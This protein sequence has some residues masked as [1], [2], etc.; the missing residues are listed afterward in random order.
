[1][2][3]LFFYLLSAIAFL[4]LLSGCN[5]NVDGTDG[6]DVDYHYEAELL[7]LTTD[8]DNPA[9]SLAND[10]IF[11]TIR[12]LYYYS[13][14]AD[15]K[16]DYRGLQLVNSTDGQTLLKYCA[17][18]MG[19]FS[20]W[21][22]LLPVA[23]VSYLTLESMRMFDDNEKHRLE[24]FWDEKTLPSGQYCTIQRC[25]GATF[26]GVDCPVEHTDSTN[27]IIITLPVKD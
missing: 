23:P 22:E 15:H 9:Q 13:E 7:F 2:R 11:G 8:G 16:P 25:S 19:G 14:I 5:D 10:D 6:F 1:M 4:T 21:K 27:R 26:D 18:T 12:G 17:S 20:T 24:M 3:K